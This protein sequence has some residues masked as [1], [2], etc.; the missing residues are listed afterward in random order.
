[1]P[2]EFWHLSFSTILLI[3][4][5][6]EKERKNGWKSERKRKEKEEEGERAG[7]EKGR[8]GKTPVCYAN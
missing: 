1:M 2:Y 6:N 3:A 7:E 4:I 8:E 5:T